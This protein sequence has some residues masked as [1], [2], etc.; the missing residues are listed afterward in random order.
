M[1]II[2]THQ[3]FWKYNA[4]DFGWVNDEMKILRTD[5]LPL[6]L[7]PILQ[8]NDVEG[9]VAVQADQSEKE[10]EF[11]LQMA[12]EN[13]FVV[14][15]V[16]WVD[17]CGELINERLKYFKQFSKLKGFRHILQGEE[18]SF[19]LQQNFLHGIGLLHQYS[20]TYDLLIY[21]QHL[22]AA[23]ELV[24]Q[25]PFQSFVI[26]HIAKPNIGKNEMDKWEKGIMDLS[27]CSNVFCKISGLVTEANWAGWTTADL[28]PYIDKVVQ[29]FGV[30][31]IMF[32]SDWPVC[33]LASSYDNWL[34]VVKEYFAS[35]SIEDQEKIF[36]K[37]AIKFYH[38]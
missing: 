26:D 4:A 17:L 12:N 15:V 21:P 34:K 36:S 16:G 1:K 35:Y 14:G 28:T 18:P 29:Y 13:P 25:F 22:S 3:H 37:N 31:R 7:Y 38:L 9:C 32:G 11:L 30:D 5:Y 23:L 2:D 19:M 20:Y 27:S 33:L 24:K 8:K 10:T 6:D